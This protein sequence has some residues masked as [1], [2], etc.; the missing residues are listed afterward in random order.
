[1]S[2]RLLLTLLVFGLGGSE[3]LSSTAPAWAKQTN[4]AASCALVA[5]TSVSEGTEQQD[6][7]NDVIGADGLCFPLR[8][9]TA[10]YHAEKR[11]A[12]TRDVTPQA[13]APPYLS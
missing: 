8:A 1:M 6:S 3:Y 13:R 10:A 4:A 12:C 7:D 9:T 2:I 11:A 5:E